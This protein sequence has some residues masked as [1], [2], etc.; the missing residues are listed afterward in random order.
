MDYFVTG[1]TGWVGAAVVAELLA[2]G[3]KVTGLVRSQD[4]AAKLEARGA[5]ALLADM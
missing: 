1:A 3:H 4:N 5:R 2:Q